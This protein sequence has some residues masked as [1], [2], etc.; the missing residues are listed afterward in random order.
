MFKVGDFVAL[1]QTPFSKFIVTRIYND[2]YMA[3]ATFDVLDGF[4]ENEYKVK[5]K[6]FTLL[7]LDKFIVPGM[8]YRHMR[9][10][11]VDCGYFSQKKDGSLIL[12]Y[13]ED[14]LNGISP[15]WGLD[16][17]FYPISAID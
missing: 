12:N 11:F 10:N 1:G 2:E 6:Y 13:T 14:S 17:K 3:I 8:S 9:K 5:Q 4:I 15:G 7:D 16:L